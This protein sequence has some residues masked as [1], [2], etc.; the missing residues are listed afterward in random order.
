MPCF[1][2]TALILLGSYEV[3]RADGYCGPP[4]AAPVLSLG[5]RESGWS[6]LHFSGDSTPHIQSVPTLEGQGVPGERARMLPHPDVSSSP[7]HFTFF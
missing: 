5:G 7:E 2:Q 6:G 4:R 3:P 1:G